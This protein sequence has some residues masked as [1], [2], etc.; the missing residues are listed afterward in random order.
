MLSQQEVEKFRTQ[1]GITTPNQAGTDPA[2]RVADLRARAGIKEPEEPGY[3]ERVGGQYMTGAKEIISSVEEGAE[4]LKEGDIVGGVARSALG[5]AGAFSRAVFAPLVELISPLAKQLIEKAQ[6]GKGGEL[7]GM[8]ATPQDV[9]RIKEIFT[10]VDQWATA[11]PE[12][13]RNLQDAVD[14]GLSLIGEPIVRKAGTQAIKSGLEGTAGVLETTAKIGKGTSEKLY[15]VAAPMAEKTALAMQTYEAAQP[16]LIGRVKNFFK[17]ESAKIGEAP[18]KE[19]E[20]AA[21]Q[22]LAGT[23]W[24]LGVQA[25]RAMTDLWEGKIGPALAGYGD[26]VNMKQFFDNVEKRIRSEVADLDRRNTL[27]EALKSMREDYKA[28]SNVSYK[29]LQDYKSGWAQFVPEK[30]YKGKP[31]AGAANE[32]RNL[33]AQEARTKI[34]DALGPEVKQAYFDYGNLDSITQI[35]RKTTDEL[36]SRGITRQIWEVVVDKALTPIFSGTG[37]T[38]YKTAEGIEFVGKSGVKKLGE[39]LEADAVTLQ[40]VF[41]GAVAGAGGLIEQAQ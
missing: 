28:V 5:T 35:A 8:L 19:S 13:A 4:K 39:L 34:Y 3:L 20:T 11:N 7:F 41:G 10:K 37:W 38:V 22:G 1:Y 6:A 21:R 40:D 30:A 18:I 25:K 23:K 2:S 15:R 27:L 16:T 31:I 24:G 29:K 12:A 26:K 32:V 33:A 14:V 9:K 36:R 17:G